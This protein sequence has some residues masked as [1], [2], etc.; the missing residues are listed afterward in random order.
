MVLVGLCW[1]CHHPSQCH[2][3][4]GCLG[5][6]AF[7]RPPQLGHHPVG[8]V[9]PC[10]WWC[11]WLAARVGDQN[12]W[13]WVIAPSFQP[14]MVFIIHEHATLSGLSP[15]IGWLME[16][17][18]FPIPFLDWPPLCPCQLQQQGKKGLAQANHQVQAG[19]TQGRRRVQL[20]Q[21][22]LVQNSCR[23]HM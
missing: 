15:V 18:E 10:H 6:L 4:Q 8:A 11:H 21:L 13:W 1:P 2:P 16:P 9:E 5:A 7:C 23:K 17:P 14:V 19:P 12:W 22:E 3:F 20:V